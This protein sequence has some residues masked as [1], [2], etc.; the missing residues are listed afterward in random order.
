M[1]KL[2]LALAFCA[3]ATCANAA[4]CFWVGGT[5]TWSTAN[6]ASWASATGG[7]AGTCAATG[8]IPKQAADTATFDGSSGGGTVTVDSTIN[9]VTL[10]QITMG[11]FTGTL[12]FSVNNP[13]ITITTQ[14]SISGSGTRTLKLGSGTFNLTIGAG[15]NTGWFASTTTGLTFNAGT[16]TIVYTGATAVSI[17][18]FQGGGLTYHNLT[19]IGNGTQPQTP[20]EILGS[21]TFSALAITGPAYVEFSSGT[22][23]TISTAF[24]FAGASSSSV[25]GLF[26]VWSSG[27]APTISIPSGTATCNWCAING[28]TFSGG[29]T[30]TASNSF[31]LKGNTGITITGPSGGGGGHIIGG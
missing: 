19:L 8:G 2:L 28:L 6:T 3:F 12:D 17:N 4:T 26:N 20:L 25:I 22:T 15:N 1:K 29:A 13:S 24:S 23:T 10:T 16:S 11:A 31:D 18:A 14:F 27:A 21:N 9:G 30:F 7:T 5:G